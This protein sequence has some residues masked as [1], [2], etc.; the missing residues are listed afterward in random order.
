MATLYSTVDVA[1]EDGPVVQDSTWAHFHG[2]KCG[3]SWGCYSQTCLLV[4]DAPVRNLITGMPS[5]FYTVDD[6]CV[7]C[8]QGKPRL[9]YDA[10]KRVTRL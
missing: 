1:N 5:K 2:C 8:R 10:G 6:E 9:T 4:R 3:H 7:R